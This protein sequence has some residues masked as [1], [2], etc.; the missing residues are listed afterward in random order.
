MKKIY[1]TGYSNFDLGIFSPNDQKNTILKLF[2]KKEITNLIESGIEWFIFAGKIGIESLAFEVVTE[3]KKEYEIK[4]CVLL[5]FKGY[6]ENFNQTNSM[7]MSKYYQLA[8]FIDSV[9]Q[10]EYEG[11][12]QYKYHEQFILNHTDGTWI[13]YDENQE[14]SKLKYFY[15]HLQEYSQ[16]NNYQILVY[17]FDDL[18]NFITEYQEY[19]QE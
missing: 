6:G 19:N 11:I 3:L 5:P 4:T 10:R 8:D 1:I 14:I 13:L 18:N 7:I 2:L 17:N 16:H 15:D 9:S 12:Y